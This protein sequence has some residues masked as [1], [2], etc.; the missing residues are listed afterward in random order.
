MF[1]GGKIKCS[2]LESWSRSASEN[3]S[4]KI[5]RKYLIKHVVKKIKLL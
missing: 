2:S 4:A 1:T 3:K 5:E